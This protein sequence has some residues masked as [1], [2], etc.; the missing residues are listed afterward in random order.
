MLLL[1][2]MVCFVQKIIV[3]GTKQSQFLLWRVN[4]PA[5]WEKVLDEMYHAALNLSLRV[6]QEQEN[7]KEVLYIFNRR[8]FMAN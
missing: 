8:L 5:L 2:D 3:T 6:A 7:G 4:K 1:T